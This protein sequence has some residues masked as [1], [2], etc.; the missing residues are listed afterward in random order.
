MRFMSLG[1]VGLA[2]L[3]TCGTTVKAQDAVRIDDDTIAIR[4]CVS[5]S[6]AQLR[7][8]FE[9]LVWSRDGILTASTAAAAAAVNHD[10][11][12]LGSRVLYWLDDDALKEHAGKLV[13]VKGE[14]EE[15]KKGELEID[16]DG[17]FTE[18]SLDLGGRDETIRV[19]SSWLE[20]QS[21]AR[22]SRD[23]GRV[24]DKKIDIATRK[25]DLKDVKVLGD[26]PVR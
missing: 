12:A 16:R 15:L 19:P 21:V 10:T 17:D 6:A 8:P 1:S 9:T 24:E 11:E 23:S 20:R 2:A 25:V 3:L 4:G 26:C 22:A 14:L 5:N 7:M 13:E 18:I